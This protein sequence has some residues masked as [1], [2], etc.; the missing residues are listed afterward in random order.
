MARL[1]LALSAPG[2]AVDVRSGSLYEPVGD[3]RFDLVLTNPPFVVSPADGERLV[4]RDSGLP[5]D[6]VVRRIVTGAPAV[7]ADGGW[8]QVLANWAHVEGQPWEQRVEGW[9]AGSGCDA[10][11]L[12]REVLDPAGYVQ[13]WLADAGLVGSPEWAA[14]YDAWLEWFEQQRI[15]AVGLGW[16]SLHRT[17]RAEP[18]VRVEDWPYAIEQPVGPEVA[19]WGRRVDVLG[20]LSAGELLGARLVRAA[21]VVQETYGEPGSADPERIVLRRGRGV[22]RA[23]PVD[24]VEA[25]PGGGVRRRADRRPGARRAG[26]AARPRPRRPALRH[27]PRR[28]RPGRGGLAHPPVIRGFWLRGPRVLV[29]RSEGS[30]CAVRG[31]WLWNPRVLVAGSGLEPGPHQPTDASELCGLD[32]GGDVGGRVVAGVR[33]AA[34]AGGGDTDE[35]VGV[36][37]AAG[38]VRARAGGDAEPTGGRDQVV[39]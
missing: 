39:T 37:V 29:A 36:V 8:C 16:L 13:M 2:A 7:L 35:L 20:G 15:E 4:Y 9:L 28:P 32:H 21:D 38:V 23:R 27:P 3:E 14:R 11:V 5:G 6:E 22:L 31:F 30:G 19:S 33:R 10:W 26:R 25:A 24:T 18:V 17:G 34:E 1:T 12:Q